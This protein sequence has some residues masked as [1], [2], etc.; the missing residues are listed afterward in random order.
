MSWRSLCF[1]KKIPS[2]SLT[3]RPWKVTK[4]PIGS[5]IVFQSHHFSGGIV[6]VKLRWCRYHF[7]RAF[8]IIHFNRAF[9]CFHHPFWGPTPI[10]GNPQIDSTVRFLQYSSVPD[11]TAGEDLRIFRLVRHLSYRAVQLVVGYILSRTRNRGKFKPESFKQKYGRKS[12]T[13][14]L[15]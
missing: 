15:F 8:Q 12:G 9:H 3:V 14:Q 4:I 1:F 10:F 5:R 11:L 6:A 13:T 2:R 7:H